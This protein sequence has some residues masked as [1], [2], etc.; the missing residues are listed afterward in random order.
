MCPVVIGVR[1][2]IKNLAHKDTK[3]FMMRKSR[4]EG[5]K[6]GW[7]EKKLKTGI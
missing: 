4:R 6:K 1:S 7:A 3:D 2:N 5:E